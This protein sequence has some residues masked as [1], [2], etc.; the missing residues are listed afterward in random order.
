MRGSCSTLSSRG[1][2]V[3]LLIPFVIPAMSSAA[4]AHQAATGWAYPQA[5]CSDQDCREVPASMVK[6]SPEGYEIG[7]TGEVVDYDDRRVRMSPDGIYHWC[8]IAGKD[9]SRTIC[10]FVPP[11]LF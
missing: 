4:G 8:S 1:V 6:E 10:L 7:P 9:D 11:R 3:I 5:C 2:A